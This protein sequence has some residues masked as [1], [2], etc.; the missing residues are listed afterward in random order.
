M[1]QWL[2]YLRRMPRLYEL[3]SNLCHQSVIMLVSFL[4]FLYKYVQHKCTP[5]FWP[6]FYC[7]WHIL[8]STS[9]TYTHTSLL[10]IRFLITKQRFRWSKILA[11]TAQY[12]DM[13]NQLSLG[14]S[15]ASAPHKKGPL[16]QQGRSQWQNKFHMYG[17]FKCRTTLHFCGSMFANILLFEWI[18]ISALWW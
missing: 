18:V 12:L 9:H 3:T 2:W 7:T 4:W 15:V 8:K 10:V 13:V 6:A 5:L 17:N 11:N 16:A 14:K 1:D